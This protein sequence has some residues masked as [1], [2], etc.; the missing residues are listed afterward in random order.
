MAHNSRINSF[1]YFSA[2][3]NSRIPLVYFLKRQID[4]RSY[5]IHSRMRIG[6]RL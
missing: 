4:E 1:V 3:G 5:L 6:T 2:K